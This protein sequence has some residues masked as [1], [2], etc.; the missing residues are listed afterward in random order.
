M[1]GSG[2]VGRTKRLPLD[3]R[4]SLPSRA[5]IRHRCTDYEDH[6]VGVD[7]L[8]AAID[9]L[10]YGAIKAAAH[11]SVDAFSRVIGND[12]DWRGALGE[13]LT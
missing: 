1:V 10:E 4:A 2:R 6:L 8:D 11:R 13:W 3:E 7:A 9:I 12:D 5:F